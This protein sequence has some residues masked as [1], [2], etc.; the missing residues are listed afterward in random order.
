V[1]GLVCSCTA[2]T[3]NAPAQGARGGESRTVHP[4][5][6]APALRRRSVTCAHATTSGLRLA[7]VITLR[8]ARHRGQIAQPR[9]RQDEPKQTNG[10]GTSALLVASASAVAESSPAASRS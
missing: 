10:T 9:A 3:R 5:R 2:E 1:S 6:A 7:Q 4:A 8:E